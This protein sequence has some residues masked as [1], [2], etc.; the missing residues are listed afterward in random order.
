MSDQNS[1]EY[2][3]PAAT[4]M[5]GLAETELGNKQPVGGN[6]RG[7]RVG[8]GQSGAGAGREGAGTHSSRRALAPN[9]PNA[10]QRRNSQHARCCWWL[11][12]SQPARHDTTRRVTAWHV[13]ARDDT[14]T[15]HTRHIEPDTQPT[16]S[17]VSS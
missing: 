8:G 4:S 3:T 1:T 2:G 17:A 14:A 10:P 11:V 13:T 5:S 12:T 15:S 6:E 16:R 7:D 9:R